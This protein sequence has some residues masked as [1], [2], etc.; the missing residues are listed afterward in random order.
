MFQTYTCT[1]LC[2]PVGRLHPH[3]RKRHFLAHNFVRRC[4]LGSTFVKIAVWFHWGGHYSRPQ[5]HIREEGPW[6]TGSEVQSKGAGMEVSCRGHMGTTV[7][8]IRMDCSVLET[9]LWKNH[10][11]ERDTVCLVT[12]CFWSQTKPCDRQRG[13][14]RTLN[15]RLDPTG[16]LPHGACLLYIFNPAW[17]FT[18]GRRSLLSVEC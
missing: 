12:L 17:H 15:P 13:P 1:T 8:A 2:F 9:V 16:R 5:I 6:D 7:S 4:Q 18:Q 10:P 3:R 14:P 11:W